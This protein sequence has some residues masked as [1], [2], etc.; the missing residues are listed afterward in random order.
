MSFG[1]LERRIIISVVLQLWWLFL[2][3]PTHVLLRSDVCFYHSACFM[4][5]FLL[6]LRTRSSQNTVINVYFYAFFSFLLILVSNII[7]YYMAKE[8]DKSNPYL[9]PIHLIMIECSNWNAKLS[10][11]STKFE[12]L[13]E[14][15]LF[16]ALVWIC[17]RVYP[18]DFL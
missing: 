8:H 13:L 3:L 2:T 18:K 6:N 9:T 10:F 16:E 5:L 1:S 15:I 17:H 4:L 12:H 7:N 14:I 11:S